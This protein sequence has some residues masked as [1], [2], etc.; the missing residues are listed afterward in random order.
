MAIERFLQLQRE[1][2]EEKMKEALTGAQRLFDED[3]RHDR[4][5]NM[6][7]SLLKDRDI[8]LAAVIAYLEERG[9]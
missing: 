1:I 6:A 5:W 9:V 7:E 4:S 2:V 8:L 3:H